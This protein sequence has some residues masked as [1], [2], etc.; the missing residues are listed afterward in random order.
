MKK[1]MKKSMF[2]VLAAT[3]GLS[4]LMLL[5]PSKYSKSEA[6]P[7]FARQTKMSCTAC[8]TTYPRLNS[9]GWQFKENGYRLPGV[10]NHATQNMDENFDLF[11]Q[12]P[13]SLKIASTVQMQSSTPNIDFQFPSEVEFKAGG[14]WGEHFSF[15]YDHPLGSG[16]EGPEGPEQAYVSFN[17]LI[18][19]GMMNLR[20]GKFNLM[21]WEFSP[22]RSWTISDYLVP[23]TQFGDNPFTSGDQNMGLE[24]YGRPMDG[25]IFYHLGIFD[26]FGD[27]EDSF[28]ANNF[29]DFSGGLSYTFDEQRVG[30]YGYYGQSAITMDTDTLISPLFN[31]GVYANLSFDPV[32]V[33]ALYS[34]GQNLDSAHQAQVQGGLLE[35]SYQW[36]LPNVWGL[37]PSLLGIARYDLAM[38]NTDSQETT[39]VLTPAVKFM[40]DP[41]MSLTLEYGF[42]LS[43][44][45]ASTGFLTL[46]TIL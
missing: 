5:I 42:N 24:V 14:S 13:L 38:V 4:A 28:D 27:A 31:T 12:V 25:P 26:G 19:P 43:D 15:F 8:H 10:E 22:H 9:F 23:T 18:Q 21:D 2:H 11:K 6:I 29:K 1:S 33:K 36:K 17:N 16:K 20:V 46:E 34:F 35:A 41:N 39:Q 32:Q 40:F 37:N 30:L 3:F 45:Q 7:A 44:M